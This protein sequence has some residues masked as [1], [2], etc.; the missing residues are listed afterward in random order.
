MTILHAA[1]DFSRRAVAAVHDLG[2]RRS[3][4]EVLVADLEEGLVGDLHE[5]SDDDEG[6]EERGSDMAGLAATAPLA[7]AAHAFGLGNGRGVV[8][9]V[10]GGWGEK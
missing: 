2:G 7:T 10:V 4:D 8:Y 9:V 3:L 6:C 5:G 1:G